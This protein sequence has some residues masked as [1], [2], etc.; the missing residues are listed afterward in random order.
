MSAPPSL[1]SVHKEYH[2]DA[3]SSA[4]VSQPG[5]RRVER[6]CLQRLDE[7]ASPGWTA[8]FEAARLCFLPSQ[9]DV[10]PQRVPLQ[11]VE[12]ERR[13]VRDAYAGRIAEVRTAELLRLS[14]D[15]RPDVLVR[16]ETDYGA[17]IAAERAAVPHAA[18]VA[19]RR[20]DR[21]AQRSPARLTLAG[22]V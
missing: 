2:L 20:A 21:A 3:P 10:A 6:C 13:V 8:A 9:P 16:D 14:A 5:E 12:R 22:R 4:A 17:A 19:R 11:H 1:A 18:A 7:R 15:W